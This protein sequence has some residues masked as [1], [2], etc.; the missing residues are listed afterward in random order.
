MA[1]SG[2]LSGTSIWSRMRPPDDEGVPLRPGAAGHKQPPWWPRGA[3][4]Q[5]QRSGSRRR[6]CTIAM[7]PCVSI[8]SPEQIAVSIAAGPGG[9]VSL[10]RLVKGKLA[11]AA[12][13]AGRRRTPGERAAAAK[14]RSSAEERAWAHLRS[15][16]LS[17]GAARP[18]AQAAAV[19]ERAWDC[20]AAAPTSCGPLELGAAAWPR[21]WGLGNLWW[22]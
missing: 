14:L 6:S 17:R 11:A 5:R 10:P 15:A 19:P 8:L 7:G 21:R 18:L 20:P 1:T 12:A 13:A 3:Q 16:V 2:V 9:S 4:P 22:R